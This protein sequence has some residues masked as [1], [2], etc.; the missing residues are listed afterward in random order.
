MD[1]D[2]LIG[3]YLLQGLRLQ[4]SNPYCRYNSSYIR[5][6]VCARLGKQIPI[7]RPSAVLRCITVR[8]SCN[9]RD[10]SGPKPKRNNVSDR[11]Y[12]TLITVPEYCPCEN[13]FTVVRTV[14]IQV[15]NSSRVRT[16][17][18]SVKF[19]LGRLLQTSRRRRATQ[20]RRCDPRR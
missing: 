15:V 16:I 13:R 2:D 3:F 14:P 17:R 7:A 19:R 20:W 1:H 8:S 6:D 10:S 12:K 4:H 5:T 18:L 11:K 9:R